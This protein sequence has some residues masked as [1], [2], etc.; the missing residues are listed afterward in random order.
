MK[1][2]RSA[3]GCVAYPGQ[4]QQP[5]LGQG[6]PWQTPVPVGPCG[7]ETAELAVLGKEAG[8]EDATSAPWKTPIGM[9]EDSDTGGNH[10]PT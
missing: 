9:T 2:G 6:E 10:G 3:H 4:Q 5:T 7:A 8:K 1:G